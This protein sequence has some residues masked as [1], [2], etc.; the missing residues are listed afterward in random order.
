MYAYQQQYRPPVVHRHQVVQ[1]P[2][3]LSQAQGKQ[4]GTVGQM[5]W[6]DWLLLGGGTIAAGVGLN[7]VYSGVT[8]RRKPNFVGILLGGVV[9]AVGVAVMGTEINKMVAPG[10]TV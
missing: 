8:Q 9:T 2:A 3:Q 5:S 10:A 4:L 1:Y 7:T 6:T